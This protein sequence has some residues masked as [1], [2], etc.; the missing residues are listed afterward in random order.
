MIR[1]TKT[2][3]TLLLLAFAWST[4]QAEEELLEPDKAFPFQVIIKD[5]ILHA[6]WNTAKGYYLY[7]NK[8]RLTTDTPGVSLG[9]PKLPNGKIKQDE[10]FGEIEVYHHPV[11]AQVPI[12]READNVTEFVL[13]AMYQ[14]CADIGVCY[15]PI[16]KQIR[17][18]LP[19][20]SGGAVAALGALG[21]SLGIGGSGG[22]DE[23]LE[24]DQAFRFSMEIAD[25]NTLIANWQIAPDHY[26]YR[27]K[28][29][30]DLPEG[31]AILPR[32]VGCSRQMPAVT[33]W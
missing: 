6:E 13:T 23:V 10:F 33:G 16:K 19:D 28:I 26:M 1:I 24:P 7:R 27:G 12:Q 8:I 29:S 3:T 31:Q 20:K 4:P 22:G 18:D 17:L 9:E 21:E 32:P 14:G 2:L 15:P 11:S 30:F 5:D 25:P